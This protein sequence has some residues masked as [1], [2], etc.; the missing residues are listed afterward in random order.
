MRGMDWPVA[1]LFVG[2]VAT[3]LFAIFSERKRKR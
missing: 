2:S 3:L 1:I